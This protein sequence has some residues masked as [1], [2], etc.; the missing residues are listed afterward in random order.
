MCR[1]K[2]HKMLKINNLRAFLRPFLGWRLAVF[3]AFLVLAALVWVFQGRSP[4]AKAPSSCAEEAVWEP[5]GH[6]RL[7]HLGHRC[8]NG[9]IEVLSFIGKDTVVYRLTVEKPVRRVVILSS[10]QI[11]F[12]TRLGIADRIVGVGE[13]KYVVDSALYARV[14]AGEVA[15]VGNGP[16]ISLEKVLALKPDLVMTFATGGSY[17]DYDR[18]QTLGIPLLVTSEWQEDNPLAKIEWIKLYGM[19]FGVDSLAAAIYEQTKTDY[20]SSLAP[21]AGSGQASRLSSNKGGVAGVAPAE[22]VADAAGGRSEGETSPRVIA[23]M[24]YG[25]VW[26]A[27]GGK[28]YTAHLVKA[29]G[30]RYLWEGD[31]TRELKLS[32]EE[33]MLLADSADVWVNPGAFGS[34]EEVLATEPRVKAL[35]A[36]R[37]KRVCQNDGRKGPGGGNDFYESAVARPVKLIADLHGCLFAENGSVSGGQSGQAGASWYRNIF[38]F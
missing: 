38:N 16:T 25:G 1:G 2:F 36:F 34:V 17:D 27:P 23:G 14:A 15:E 35:K 26:Y 28:S 9:E 8:G 31:T 10:A 37:D 5:M 29:A 22:G 12:M 21:S 33:V 7:L 4:E 19:L 11:G 30:G 32:L 18:L 20:L 13:G 6:S 3:C 24:A